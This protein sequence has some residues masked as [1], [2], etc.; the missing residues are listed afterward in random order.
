MTIKIELI[1]FFLGL[2]VSVLTAVIAWVSRV[3]IKCTEAIDA[4]NITLAKMTVSSEYE[5]KDCI[6]RH[7]YVNGKI[8]SHSKQIE[9]HEKRILQIEG[10]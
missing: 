10:K 5:E 9:N 2:F 7:E 4:I 3:V 8:Q 1:I 6:L